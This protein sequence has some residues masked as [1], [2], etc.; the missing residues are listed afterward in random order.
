[1]SGDLEIRK[2]Y[3]EYLAGKGRPIEEFIAE[4][5]K[6]AQRKTRRRRRA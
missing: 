3:Q 6:E 5:R 2:S 4:L 1:M